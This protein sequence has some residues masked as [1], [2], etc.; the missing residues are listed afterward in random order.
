MQS[1]DVYTHINENH[2]TNDMPSTSAAGTQPSRRGL[3]ARPTTLRVVIVLLAVVV[4]LGTCGVLFQHSSSNEWD[5]TAGATK[6]RAARQA[7]RQV[8]EPG[9]LQ[10][11]DIPGPVPKRRSKPI[12]T[13]EEHAKE[14][15][16]TGARG[17]PW[18]P[19][20]TF[21]KTQRPKGGPALRSYLA[22]VERVVAFEDDD[23]AYP[24]PELDSVFAAAMPP[25][26]PPLCHAFAG[27]NSYESAQYWR[28]TLP[29]AAPELIKMY[30]ELMVEPVKRPKTSRFKLVDKFQNKWCWRDS[31]AKGKRKEQ[32]V[33]HCLPMAMM[34]GFVKCGSTGEEE[35][36]ECWVLGAVF[37]LLCGSQWGWCRCWYWWLCLES[38]QS[39]LM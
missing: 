20:P 35:E 6:V 14:P 16:V 12:K 36:E 3:C 4:I 30:T 38:Q 7:R 15:F 19:C 13:V 1:W 31:K 33:H 27:Y 28:K 10:P 26:P 23:E 18:R 2:Q 34:Y 5:T 39:W 8:M 11:K 9:T 29:R 17:T 32:E 37:L 24:Q 22:K 25:P 21:S